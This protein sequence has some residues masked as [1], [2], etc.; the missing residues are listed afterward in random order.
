MLQIL[1]SWI[2]LLCD[3]LQDTSFTCLRWRSCSP[4]SGRVR[5]YLQP[6]MSRR[7]RKVDNILGR[8]LLFS[9]LT[10]DLLIHWQNDNTALIQYLCSRKRRSICTSAWLCRYTEFQL[11]FHH[12]LLVCFSTSVSAGIIFSPPYYLNY[13]VFLRKLPFMYCS[14]SSTIMYRYHMILDIYSTDIIIWNVAV[15]MPFIVER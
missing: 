1:R 15:R 14:T 6:V 2:Q 8:F 10:V 12:H 7:M 11:I 13:P 3:S 5:I 9:F 4:S